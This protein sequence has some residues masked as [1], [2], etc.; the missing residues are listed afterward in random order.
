MGRGRNQEYKEGREVLTWLLFSNKLDP[1]K[2]EEF[3]IRA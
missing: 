2:P 1:R 3:F